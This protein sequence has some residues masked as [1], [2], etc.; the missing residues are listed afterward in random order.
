MSL[1]VAD[2]LLPRT[3]DIAKSDSNSS[4][5]SDAQQQEFAQLFQKKTE[6]VSKQVI[7]VNKSEKNSVNKDGKNNDKESKQKKKQRTSNVK[8]KQNKG[9]SSMYDVSI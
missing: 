9:T 2:V 8:E 1:R 6:E 4:Y 5:R 7:E 3:L